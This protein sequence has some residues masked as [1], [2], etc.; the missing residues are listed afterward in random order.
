MKSLAIKHKFT[1]SPVTLPA[2]SE[3]E[4]PRKERFFRI[5]C[6]ILNG[7]MKAYYTELTDPHEK[8]RFQPD[9]ADV[10]TEA[11]TIQRKRG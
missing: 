11:V 6:S 8:E 5:Y 2:N 7:L 1:K 9:M 4:L 10:V 3:K